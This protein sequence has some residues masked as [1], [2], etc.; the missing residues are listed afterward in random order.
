MSPETQELIM[1]LINNYLPSIVAVIT[2]ICS[3]VVAIKKVKGISQNSAVELR[4]MNA[5]LSRELTQS[6]KDNREL[7][8]LLTKTVAAQN[9][10]HLPEEK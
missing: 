8:A 1:T 2:A 9:K 7:K 4:K 3:M 5:A 6:K 10:I